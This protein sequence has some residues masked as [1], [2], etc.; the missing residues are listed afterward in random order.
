MFDLVIR[1]GLTLDGTGSPARRVDVGIRGDRIADVDDLARAEARKTIDA[2]GKV[3]APGFIDV[4]SH[5]DAYL[6]IEP[7]APSKIFQGVTT[8]VVGN[9]GASAAPITGAYGMPSDWRAQQYPRPWSTVAEYREVLEESKPGLNLVLLI[10]HN[11]IRAGVMGYEARAARS[12]EVQAMA[13][14]LDQALDEGGAGLSTGLVYQPGMFAESSEIV[15]LAHVAAKRNRIYTSHMRS[16]GAKLLE[17]ID[18]TLDV[19][20]RAGIRVQV[21]H[22]KTSGR[23]NW[24]LLDG[25]LERIRKA[26]DEGLEVASD[27]YPYTASCTDLDVILPDWASGG[28]REIVLGRLRDPSTRAK[29]REGILKARDE[30]YWPTVMI[31]STW[32]PDNARFQGERVPDIAR[33]LGVEPVDA[34]LHLMETDELRTTAIFFGMSEEN[35]WR[36]LA[37]P[38][39]MIGSDGSLRSPTGVLSKDHPHPR[40]YGSFPRFI[41]ASLEG[42]TVPLPEAVRK[43]TSLCAEQF[44]LKDRGVIAPGKLAD[45]VVFDADRVQ[46]RSTFVKPHQLSDGVDTV[47]VNGVLTLHEGRYTGDR[48]GRFLG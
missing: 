1:N 5:S 30:Q 31:G 20:R 37:E 21:S 6:I 13:K 19:G 33:A 4:H 36:I 17:A 39:V 22:L 15:E 2:S 16:E 28:G 47:I 7:S 10:G 46:E 38:Y 9:C 14:L 11:A 45:V 8:E 27:R 25:A 41:R 43:M 44:R 3:V 48:G 18:E 35:M 32:H 42:R 29:I 24:H 40:A 34:A 26:R 12:D 23:R